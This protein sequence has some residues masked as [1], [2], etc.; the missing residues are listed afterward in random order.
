MVLGT[1]NCGWSC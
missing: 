1:W